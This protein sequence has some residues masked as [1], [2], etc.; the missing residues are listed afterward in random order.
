M[1]TAAGALAPGGP[2]MPLDGLLLLPAMVNGHLHLD[3]TFAGAAWRPHIPG[4]SIA[5]RIAAEQAERALVPLPPAERARLLVERSI[6]FGV[7]AMRS[8]VDVDEDIGLDHV[9]AMLE[10]REELGDRIDLQLV[11]FPQGGARGRVADLLGEALRLGIDVVGGLD[12]AGIDGDIEHHLDIVL[13]LAERHGR[14][15]DIHLHDPGSLGAF[16]L[17]RIA[18]RTRRSGLQGRVAVSHAFALGMI[19]P[20]ELAET[21]AA[22]AEAGV[23]I[24]TNGPG[25]DSMPPLRELVR[26]G[27]LLFGGSDNIRDSWSPYGDGD[28][29][30]RAGIIGYR[31]DFRSDDE[32]R[33]AFDMVSAN[34]RRV[35]GLE[36]VSLVEGSPAD[37]VAVRASDIPEAVVDAPVGRLVFRAGE[38]VAGTPPS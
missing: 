25:A 32:L 22:L 14:R 16:E 29:L 1:V 31:A 20:A 13:G 5:A 24:M 11:A 21:A 30:R 4:D 10:L 33:L 23:A 38:L 28:L 6:A 9:E 18:A 2:S 3:K 37:F 7:L 35:M 17:R 36:P 19:A 27:V 26:A 15:V 34:G 8:H 12:P